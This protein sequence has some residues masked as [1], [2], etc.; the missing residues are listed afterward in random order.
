MNQVELLGGPQDGLILSCPLDAGELLLPVPGSAFEN[1]DPD[2][3]KNVATHMVARVLVYRR[4][5]Q[6]SA[7]G[8]V[9]YAFYAPNEEL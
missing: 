4:T 3:G 7:R 9:V 2:L 5:N 1:F 6:T 8:H